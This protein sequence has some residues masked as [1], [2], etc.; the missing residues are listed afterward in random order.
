M[1][2]PD[3]NTLQFPKQ[4]A[5]AVGLHACEI[6]AMRDRGCRFYGRKTC[7]RWVREFLEKQT[8]QTTQNRFQE[9][10]S[11]KEVFN[12]MRKH[13]P[14]SAGA[15]QKLICGHFGISKV[16]FYRC[17]REIISRRLF[18]VRNLK[19]AAAEAKPPETA[20]DEHLPPKAG[21]KSHEQAASSGSPDA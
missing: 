13:A 4:L 7:L 6:R 11:W 10:V 8:S 16:T 3:E 12:E 2:H 15:W 18:D 9:N 20:T 21:C 19:W 17:W 1:N 5:P 14:R